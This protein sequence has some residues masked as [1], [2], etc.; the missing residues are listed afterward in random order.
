MTGA[1][2]TPP[3]TPTQSVAEKALDTERPAPE[4]ILETNP[5][6]T[7]SSAP[8]LT[9]GSQVETATTTSN[10]ITVGSETGRD[11]QDRG[12]QSEGLT[13]TASQYGRDMGRRASEAYEQGR[14]G[15]SRGVSS[16]QSV[17]ADNPL[18]GIAVGAVVGV[19]VGY[20]IGQMTAS[21]RNIGTRRYDDRD[22]FGDRGGYP[23]GYGGSYS[24]SSHYPDGGPRT[25]IHRYADRVRYSDG[26]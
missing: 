21:T 19:M 17:L 23:A 14:Q 4:K 13:E 26:I 15:V 9:S 16:A 8:S 3:T 10:T 2:G 6:S 25:D 12:E 18:V 20:L 11:R 7:A 1:T 5:P 22:E 24:G